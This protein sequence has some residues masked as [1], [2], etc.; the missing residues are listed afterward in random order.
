MD[1]QT[2]RQTDGQIILQTDVQMNV[3]TGGQMDRQTDEQMNLQMI[4]HID[5]S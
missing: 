3:Q 5:V 1:E 4:V 2:N